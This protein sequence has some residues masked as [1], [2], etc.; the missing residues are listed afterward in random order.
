M[1]TQLGLY[2]EALRLIGE[3]KLADL[4][5]NRPGRHDLDTVWDN[6][7]IDFVLE[8]GQWNFA[9]RAVK[10]SASTETVPSFGLTNAY[11]KPSDHMRTTAVCED[12]YFKQPLLHYVE[13]VGFWF[14]EI[15]PIYV[16]YV[17]N[18]SDYGNDLTRWP[19]SFTRYV[20]AYLAAEIAW[21]VTQDVEKKTISLQIR[22]ERLKLARSRDAM[23]DPT[24]F[25][26]QGNWTASRQRGS[27]RDRGSRS[28]LIG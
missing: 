12:E 3:R 17:S 2:N 7:L 25:P 1:A 11:D 19:E 10:I 28:R 26:P 4:T 15:D 20:G 5:E 13:E 8:Q 23:A 9:M 22:D 18:A 24:A 21:T 6:G 14:A 27:R 16:R